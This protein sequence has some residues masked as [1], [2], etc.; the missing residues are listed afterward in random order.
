MD[1]IEKYLGEGDIP[2]Y[3]S[4]E[5]YDKFGGHGEIGNW[6]SFDMAYKKAM[7]LYK[8]EKKEGELGTSTGYIGVSGNGDEFAI[9]YLDQ[10]YLKNMN[11]S[12]FGDPKA[13]KA[14]MNVAK[15][16]LATGKPMKGKF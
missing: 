3:Y 5:Y 14:W 16:V 2:T 11:A 6:S 8:R 9:I 10:S 4:A 15:K 1:L 12:S 7:D 13:F